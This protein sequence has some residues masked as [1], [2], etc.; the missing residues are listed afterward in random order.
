MIYGESRLKNV[1]PDLV[2]LVHAVGDNPP[3]GP[4][5]DIEVVQ[6]ARS[7][8]DEQRDI[9]AGVS[10]LS[11]PMHSKHVIGPGRPL[12]E[13]VDLALYPVVWTDHLSFVKMSNLMKQAAKALSIQISWGGDWPHPFDF[14]HIELGTGPSA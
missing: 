4:S 1:H 7:V 2:K 8:A 3:V 5:V 10:H 6:G 14:D 12:A 13:A 11:D 9:D